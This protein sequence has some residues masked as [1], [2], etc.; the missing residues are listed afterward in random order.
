MIFSNKNYRLM[1]VSHIGTK[2]VEQLDKSDHIAVEKACVNNPSA[3]YVIATIDWDEK[4]HA[5]DVN[6]V[7]DRIL[8]VDDDDWA[9]VKAFIKLGIDMIKLAHMENGN[10]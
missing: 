6:C 5:C 3:Y 10:D 1:E 2:G 9:K 8:D 7:G 4:E